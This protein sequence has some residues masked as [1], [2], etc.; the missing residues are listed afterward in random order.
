MNPED[1]KSKSGR[2]QRPKSTATMTKLFKP[3][4]GIVVVSLV[5]I[6]LSNGF[7]LLLPK[8]V[9]NYIDA[10]QSNPNGS[11]NYLILAILVI[12]IF[13]VATLQ[14]V[15]TTYL[16]EKIASDLRG[17]L[18]NKI[19]NSSFSFVNKIGP[20]ELITTFSSDITNVKSIASQGLVYFLTA[21]ILLIGSCI[22]MLITNWY[23]A[24]I[25]MSILPIVIG[26]FVFIFSQISPLFRKAQLNISQINQVVNES[27]FGSSLIR[28]L[29]SQNWEEEKF[30]KVNEKA[31]NISLE[32]VNLFSLLIPSINLVSNLAVVVILYIGGR[33]IVDSSLTIGQFTSFVTYFNL[34]ITP[35]F[36]LGFT[37]QSFSRG[38]VSYARIQEVLD[39]PDQVYDG[40]H[41]AEIKGDIT[42]KDLNL[43]MGGRQVLKDI[44]F[45][46]KSGS[47]T[48]I[49]GPTGAGK[50]QLFNLLIGLSDPT[51][52]E[53]MIDGI[54]LKEWERDNLL[55][56]IGMVFQDSLV[57]R[58]SIKE[59]IVFS[60]LVSNEN[61]N[62]AIYT[63]RLDEFVDSLES[64]L[65]T[66]VSERG[67]TLSGGQKQRLMLARSLALEPKVLL[68]DDFTARVDNQ[69]E[70]EIWRRLKQN[71]PTI[72]LVSITQKIEAVKDFDQIIV[73]MEGE[74]VGIGTHEQLLK[75]S[76]EYQQIYSSQQTVEN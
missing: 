24:L 7:N 8:L 41:K 2:P 20:S 57:F 32:V 59:N 76:S 75:T 45:S 53:I 50:S 16:S 37:S 66:Q 14:I 25:A 28:I 22:M 1:Q 38:F 58:G 39:A 19:S 60:N 18:I 51:S 15:I 11:Q 47:R 3:Y 69:T 27:I 23:L 62:N 73:L 29:N 30:K 54:N 67:A 63:S 44:N 31:R 9:G 36:I 10:F 40:E 6:L 34:L 46:I 71:Y 52:G 56:Q 64:G 35:I 17:Q 48:A 4:T 72:T 33:Q 42:V 74:L 13:L 55:S 43:V 26:V 65:E 21:V 12:G 5:V 49:L 70:Q 61:L 68:L